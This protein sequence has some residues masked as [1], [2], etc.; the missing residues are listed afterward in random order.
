MTLHSHTLNLY[1]FLLKFL[2]EIKTIYKLVVG[3]FVAQLIA[4][5]TNSEKAIN[6]LF[7]TMTGSI[8][9]LKSCMLFSCNDSTEILSFKFEV[10]L[11]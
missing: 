3:N 2:L 6:R 10:F 4:K 9:K 8:N 5:T 7:V 11:K 1:S